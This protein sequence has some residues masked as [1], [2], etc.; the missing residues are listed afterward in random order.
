M[1]NQ[2]P[3]FGSLM[4]DT[5]TD[6]GNTSYGAAIDDYQAQMDDF[7]LKGPNAQFI[8]SN[9]NYDEEGSRGGC[10][11]ALEAALEK[12][13]CL[14]DIVLP[15]QL[16][17]SSSWTHSASSFKPANP[18]FDP[19]ACSASITSAIS[20]QAVGING[21]NVTIEWTRVNNDPD[22]QAS[23]SINWIISPNRNGTPNYRPSWSGARGDTTV[24]NKDYTTGTYYIYAYGVNLDNN[25]II[26]QYQYKG[27]LKVST[28][29]E[30]EPPVL[31]PNIQRSFEVT[32]T[33]VEGEDLP[34][35]VTEPEPEP[36]V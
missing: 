28:S 19:I 31:T 23:G 12:I 11:Q 20:A 6:L 3:D 5:F 35:D 32:N 2:E 26:E 16:N 34:C 25:Q 15:E 18:P 17:G 22:C 13:D 8:A 10:C 14:T 24:V 36:E 4:P 29:M 7:D 27:T 33:V 21:P 9:A 30:G 1:M